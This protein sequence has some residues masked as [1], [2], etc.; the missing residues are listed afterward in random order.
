MHVHNRWSVPLLAIASVLSLGWTAGAAGLAASPHHQFVGGPWEVLLKM[1][2]EGSAVRVPVTVTNESK[3]QSLDAMVPVAGTPI[4]VRLERYL[5]NLKWETNATEDPNGGPAARLSLRGEGL[6]QDLWLCARD[7]ERQSITAHIGSVAIREL[8]GPVSPSALKELTDP[9]TVGV[10]AIWLSEGGSPLVY[11]VK[12]GKT[13]DLPDS[14]WKLSVLRYVPHY[15][16]DRAT[17]K[18]TNLSDKPENPAIEVRVEGD[19][20]DRQQWLWSRF[21]MA[22]HKTE[23][24]PFRARFVDFQVESGAGR[25]L[26]AVA[27]GRRSYLFHFEDGKRCIEP[28]EPAQRYLFEDKRYSFAVEEVR[29]HVRI[30]T[31]WKDGSEVLLHPAVVAIISQGNAT[32]QVVLEL[33]QPCHH[34]TTL[35]T[36]VLLY[37]HVPDATK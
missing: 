27:P 11:A 37:R 23:Q 8:P 3:S 6:Q 33:G 32:R 17:K 15:S 28:M 29:P 9:N 24:L 2:L 13:V 1:G 35:G 20:R 30:A 10:L 12:P 5:P 31:A 25:Y 7:R 18:V 14:S 16:I 36:L 26:L 4:R 19:Q 34:K 21:S 22:P